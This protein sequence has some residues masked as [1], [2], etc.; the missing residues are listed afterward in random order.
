MKQAPQERTGRGAGCASP[1]PGRRR[2]T[3]WSVAGGGLLATVS[4]LAQGTPPPGSP[5]L[6]AMA[7]P[8]AAARFAVRGFRVQGDN[9]LGAAETEAVLAPFVRPDATLQSLQD[10]SAALEKALR[11]RGFGLHR[12]VLPPQ[13]VGDV[14]RL[15]VLRFT[16]GQV[17]VEGAV[18]N[19]EANIRRSLPELQEGRSPNLRQLAVQTAIANE[20]ASKQVQ[21]GLREGAQPDRIDATV[22]VKEQRPWTFSAGIANSGTRETGR[23]RVSITAGHSN[24]FDL[25]HQ[26]NLAYTTS[27]ERPGDVKQMGLAYRV[28]LYARGSALG[29]NYTRSDVVGNFGSFTSTGAGHTLGLV[30]TRYLPPDGGYRGYL[31][32]GLE[33]KLFKATE[34]S[35]V[36]VGVDRRSRP[37]TLGYAGR[38]ESD[39]SVLAY[40]LDLA[41]NL[42]GG[43]GNSLAAW[44]QEDPRVATVHFKVL[45]GGAAWLAPVAGWQASLR[46]QFQ[47]SP[48]VLIAGEQFGLG[49][50][51]SVRGTALERPIRGDRGLSGSVEMATPEVAPGLHAIGFV[52]A[53]WLWNNDPNAGS[54]PASDRLASVGLGLRYVR[55]PV[56][57]SADYGRLVRGS[58]VPTG[59][60]SAAPRTGDDRFYVNLAVKF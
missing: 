4:A 17:R 14:V 28:P 29:L 36:P 43:T 18:R 8:A 50:Q 31:N 56:L 42:P 39:V 16:L 27:L 25:D 49:G 1:V 23:D 9:P 60:D 35:G 58:R 30:F 44:Q 12:V 48:D 3:A 13:E 15:D 52:D 41:L 10:A 32:L 6:P 37:V 47:H 2:A 46:A 54:R 11:A 59:L 19:D 24:L 40:N 33:D 45:R 55:E 38:L 34:I 5:A 22:T 20:N 7:A 53:G 57:L 26:L 51:G 21:V